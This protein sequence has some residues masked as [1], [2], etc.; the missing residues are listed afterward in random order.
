[1][2]YVQA[3]VQSILSQ[4]FEDWEC[5]IIDDCS[6]DGTWDFLQTLTDPRFTVYRTPTNSHVAVTGNLA[7]NLARGRY[8]AR[9]DQDDVALP[10]RLADQVAYLE[11]HQDIAVLG[12]A[13][14]R[15]GDQ[16]GL[17]QLPSGDAEIK[18]N[19]LPAMGNIANPTSMVRLAFIR[20]HHLYF[21]ARFPLTCDYG[22]WVECMLK[23]ARFANLE[24][25]TTQY[26]VHEKQGS[27]QMRAMREGVQRIRTLLLMHWFPELSASDNF[28][29][30]PLLHAYGPPTL[31]LNLIRQGLASCEHLLARPTS[32]CHG[33]NRSEVY[34]YINSRREIWKKAIT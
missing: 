26:R 34:K 4:T 13:L 8:L 31:S 27:R 7:I 24:Q 30:E 25:P 19:F 2:S 28:A 11:R 14:E 16:S 29:L 5:I 3:A 12:S 22:F 6:T 1:M 15:I 10:N 33:E 21:D 32:S 23:G 20:E 18:A 17:I 9:L